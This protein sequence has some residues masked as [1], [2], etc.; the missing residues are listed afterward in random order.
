MIKAFDVLSHE[1]R[2][3]EN[4]DRQKEIVVRAG[5]FY[6]KCKNCKAKNHSL[7]RVR[8]NKNMRIRVHF[9]A[10]CGNCRTTIQLNAKMKF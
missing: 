9:I 1:I 3:V 8:G 5:D 10:L 7:T 2:E 6:G 4:L